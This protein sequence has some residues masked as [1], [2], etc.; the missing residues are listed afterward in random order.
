MAVNHISVR[1]ARVALRN[2]EPVVLPYARIAGVGANVSHEMNFEIGYFLT[3]DPLFF[4][5]S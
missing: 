5:A 4:C 3:D 1:I 2:L